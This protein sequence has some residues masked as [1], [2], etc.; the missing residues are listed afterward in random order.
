MAVTNADG[1]VRISGQVPA[2]DWPL[3]AFHWLLVFCI[4]SAWASH[5]FA[6]MLGD[7]TLKWHRWNGY[8]IL[9]LLVFRLIWGLIGGSTAR[10]RNFVRGPFFT[11]RYAMDFSRGLKR[12]FL[13]HN[14]LG[15][16]MI[17]VLLMALA[18]QGVLGLFTLEHNEIV[19]G[20]LKRL[21][22]D[23]TTAW[24]SKLHVRFFDVLVILIGVHILANLGYA[25]IAREPL[26]RAMMT[27]RKPV[28]HYED[29]A[30]AEFPPGLTVRALLTLCAAACIVF[31]GIVLA[32]GRIL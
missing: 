4:L 22:G 2:W 12:P 28:M 16:V 3:R 32:G 1:P 24:V 19:A 27:G 26:I 18:F 23:E 11:L 6:P 17:L 15:T 29:Q 21:I 31:G 25:F 9:V 7:I 10:F 14:P 8:V 20:S 13:G 5:R 30:S